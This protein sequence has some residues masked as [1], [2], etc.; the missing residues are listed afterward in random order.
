MNGRRA[1]REIRPAQIPLGDFCYWK[2]PTD[3]ERGIVVA[4]A[5]GRFRLICRGDKV[6]HLCVIAERL[7]TVS[8]SFRDVELVSVYARKLELLP[9]AVSWRIQP[10]IN[11]DIQNGSLGAAD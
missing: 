9:A 7:E 4:N 2:R 1:G 5:V 6:V 8:E 10:D 3:S 11:N